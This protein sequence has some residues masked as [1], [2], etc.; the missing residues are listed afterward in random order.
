MAMATVARAWTRTVAG[1][2]VKD[3]FLVLMFLLVVVAAPLASA[4]HASFP[5]FELFVP[6]FLG[7]AVLFMMLVL[8]PCSCFTPP[9]SSSWL[10][11]WCFSQVEAAESTTSCSWV[12]YLAVEVVR[13]SMLGR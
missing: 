2:P 11:R 13:C 1:A 3:F 10:A 8:S 7:A 6:L 12:F 9:Q 4:C 5:A